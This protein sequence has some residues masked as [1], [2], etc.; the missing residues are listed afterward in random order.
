MTVL[1]LASVLLGTAS[2]AA[3][4]FLFKGKDSTHIKRS[5]SKKESA[6]CGGSA[7]PSFVR[8]AL[9]YRGGESKW[10]CLGGRRE[11]GR[12]G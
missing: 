2:A 11:G 10:R 3:G 1:L 9:R 6:V 12:E 7:V 5:S 8:L 4:G